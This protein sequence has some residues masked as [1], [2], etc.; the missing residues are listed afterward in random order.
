MPY[1]P[2]HV[3]GL[4]PWLDLAQEVI[5]VD[6]FSTDGTVDYLRKNLAHPNITY[7]SHP[8]GLYASWNH[9]ISQIKQPY[10]YLA[11][12]GDLIAREGITKLVATAEN[13]ACDVVI[14]KP[15]FR[16]RQDQPLPDLH[17]PIDDVISTL[18]ITAPRKLQK[19]ETVLFTAL[20]PGGTLLGSSASNLYRTETFRRLPFPTD[21]GTKGDGAWVLM[22]A[23][24]ISVAVMP[25]KFS[26]FLVHPTN[27]SAEEKKSHDQ[28]RPA[29]EIL[30]AAM[31]SWRRT[32]VIN[33]RE[34]ACLR[35]DDLLAWFGAHLEAKTAFDRSRRRLYPWV[36]N[37]SAWRSRMA[38]QCLQKKLQALKQQVLAAGF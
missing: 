29:D 1:L 9:G 17:W 20:H 37:P 31:Q 35:W 2:A 25:G 14:S 27:A 8:P 21:F 34:Y 26:S 4:K 22:H 11:T 5:V 33:D 3:A 7:A 28:S 16:D 6:S 32:G 12:T 13:L 24:E 19:I 38:R 23:A 18:K 10:F 36:L 15:T 30:R